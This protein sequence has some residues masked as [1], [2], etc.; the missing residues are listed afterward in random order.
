MTSPEDDGL[1]VENRAYREYKAN[2]CCNFVVILYN[3]RVLQRYKSK[4]ENK[5]PVG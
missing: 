3:L 2:F 4:Y 1:V 5:V